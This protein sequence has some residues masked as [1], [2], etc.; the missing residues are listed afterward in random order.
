[1]ADGD[2]EEEQGKKGGSK[3]LLIVILA[4][5]GV[6]LLVVVIIATLWLSGFFTR[7]EVQSAA[8]RLN[9][10]EEEQMPGGVAG[11]AAGGGD[12][13]A[14]RAPR[15]PSRTVTP[16]QRFEASYLELPRA[17]L[18]NVSNSRKVI[19][20]Q[21][22][23]MTHYDSRVFDNVDRHHF[24]IRSAILDRL[25]QITEAEMD[26]VDFRRNLAEEIQ[27]IINSKLEELEGF[28]GIEAVHF[29]EFV[30]Q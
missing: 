10:L 30:V 19:Q 13:S 4:V 7:S 5:V 16:R 9:A 8:D 23:L 26:S 1:M 27:L 14:L 28:G 24:A 22:A 20:L 25:R 12:P 6:L 3:V 18:A 11:S 21:I 17:L 29:T 15:P 2:L